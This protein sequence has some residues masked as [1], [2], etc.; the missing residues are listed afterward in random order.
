MKLQLIERISRHA[1]TAV[2]IIGIIL[3][4]NK[5]IMPTGMIVL[6]LLSGGN[7]RIPFQKLSADP[8]NHLC[9]FHCRTVLFISKK[10]RI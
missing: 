1:V 8:Q 3:L 2:L 6:L 10:S 7:H 5:G 4:A 9:P